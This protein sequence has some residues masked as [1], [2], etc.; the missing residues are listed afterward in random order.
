MGRY[1]EDIL[2]PGEKVLYS[3]TIHGIVYALGCYASRVRALA[4][5]RRVGALFSRWPRWEPC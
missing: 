4:S 3:T 5:W 2:Q 1:I